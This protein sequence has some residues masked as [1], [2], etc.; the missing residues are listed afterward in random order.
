M[1]NKKIGNILFLPEQ[2]FGIGIDSVF[3]YQCITKTVEC[4]NCY[5]IS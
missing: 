1:I 5:I 3:A 4:T 2:F